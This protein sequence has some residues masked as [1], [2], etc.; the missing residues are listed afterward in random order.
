MAFYFKNTNKDIF[1]T[2]E[3][4]EEYRSENICSFCEKEIISDKVRDDCYLAC[5]YRGP[6]HNACNIYVTILTKYIY[7]TYMSEFQYL[8]LSFLKEIGL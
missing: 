1:M 4:E 5:K 7:P 2:G 8:S 6:T 3:D